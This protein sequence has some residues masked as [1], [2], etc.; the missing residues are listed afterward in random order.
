LT[1]NC[2]GGDPPMTVHEPVLVM[3][4]NRPDQLAVLLQRLREVQPDR[5]FVA[6][7]GPRS[8]RSEEAALVQ[9]CRDLVSTVDWPCEVR[10]LFQPENLGCGLGVSTAIS[11]FFDCVERGVI[12]EDDVIPDPS[13]FP[14]CAELLDRYQDDAR[15]FAIS[16][17]NFVPGAKQQWPDQPYRFSQ[18][19]HIWGW[20]TWRRSWERYHLDI[21]GWR[22]RLPIRRL[23]G[24][25]GH[26]VPGTVFWA[27][28]FELLARKEV[29][30]W[31][32]QFVFAAM[33]NDAL[34]ATSNVNLVENIGFGP[35]ATHT[36][37]D[38]QELQPLRPMVLPV[39]D[40]PVVQDVKADA[41]T[42]RHHFLATWRGML[43][44]FGRYLRARNRRPR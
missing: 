34:T 15:V 4:F 14:F 22:S 8:N 35:T 37:V 42:R 16:G 44:Q 10:T 26:S 12:L 41:W 9:A 40:V 39:P 6:I 25:V 11:W 7:D 38:R 5:L 43:G 28:N 36:F 33:A 20:A 19:P 27:T 29:D 32:C 18:V 30:T 17:C 31:D 1:S 2:D 24:A 23:W 13:F 3:A 21:A